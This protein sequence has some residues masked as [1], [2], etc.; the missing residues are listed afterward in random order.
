MTGKWQT[1]EVIRWLTEADQSELEELIEESGDEAAEAV[2]EW[3]RAGNAPKG[4]YDAFHR[5]PKSMFDEVDWEEV[6]ER[7]IRTVN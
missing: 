1:E 3:V 4:L 6:V 5:P 7:V 2:E